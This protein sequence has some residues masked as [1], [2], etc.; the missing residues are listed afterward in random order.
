MTDIHGELDVQQRSKE[1]LEHQRRLMVQ[2]ITALQNNPLPLPPPTEEK[3]QNNHLP[4]V[5]QLQFARNQLDQ[6]IQFIHRHMQD[7]TREL[8]VEQSRVR[9]RFHAISRSLLASMDKFLTR[10]ESH[11]NEI[12][13]GKTLEKLVF[14]VE[15][16]KELVS[17]VDVFPFACLFLFVHTEYR[18]GH[19]S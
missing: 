19:L 1:Q 4:T 15:V 5:A 10:W 8:R 9:H 2:D 3:Q 11:A 12:C 6:R 18:P 7:L 13:F 16:S 14:Q 17:F